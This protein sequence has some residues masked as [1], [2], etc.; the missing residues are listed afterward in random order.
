MK[1]ILPVL[2]IG[3]GILLVLGPVGWLYFDGLVSHPAVIPLP[4]EI[5]GLQM[6]DHKTG[7][8]AVVEFERLHE[9]PFPL[10]SGAIGIYGNQQITLWAAGAPLNF[11]ASEMMDAMR[12][13]IAEGNSPFTPMA[14]INDNS[15]KVYVLE[16]M[17]QRH[18]YF[19][20]KNLVIWLAAD[21]AV[22]DTA[23]QQILE[24]FP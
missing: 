3:L 19:Q 18:Y 2:L 10:I 22:A 9:N 15:R 23:I 8:Q 7:A 11:M 1:R 6:T 21:P 13:K 4:D 14:E 17:G 24:A 5:A 16:G 12:G 20:S